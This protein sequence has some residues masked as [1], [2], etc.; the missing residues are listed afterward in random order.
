MS[1]NARNSNNIIRIVVTV[2][3][4]VGAIAYSVQTGGFVF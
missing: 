3:V 1:K 4:V 2:V